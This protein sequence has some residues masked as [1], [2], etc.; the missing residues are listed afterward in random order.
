MKSKKTSLVSLLAHTSL[1]I[2]ALLPLAA[3]AFQV[4]SLSPQGEVTRVRQLVVKFD[5]SAIAFG[6]PKAAAPLS[7]SCSD[8]Q[9]SKGSGRWVTDRAWAYEFENDLPPGVSCSAQ[10]NAGLKSAKG[11]DLSGPQNYRFNTGGPF[12]QSLRPYE[13]SRIDEDQFF[14]LQLSGD[15]SAASVQAHVWCAMEGLGERIAVRLIDGADRTA[16]L[17]SQGWEREAAKRPLAFVTLACQRRL[18]PSARCNWC[19]KKVWPH[20]AA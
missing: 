13:S 14:V 5:D 16:L 2:A 10:M 8:A 1:C 3:G 7:L 20:P 11:A 19:L 15:A 17:K 12:V 6:D 4:A 18:T 9:A